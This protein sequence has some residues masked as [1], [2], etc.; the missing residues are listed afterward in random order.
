[1]SSSL[2]KNNK[3]L[4]IWKAQI[5]SEKDKMPFLLFSLVI[6]LDTYIVIS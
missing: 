4:T 1:M 2:N 6:Y 3:N 5:S